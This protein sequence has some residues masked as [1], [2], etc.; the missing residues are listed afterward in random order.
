MKIKAKIAGL[1]L[2]GTSFM[3]VPIFTYLIINWDK[4]TQ[5]VPG[6]VIPES[7]K[8]SAGMLVGL[9]IAGLASVGKIKLSGGWLF[10]GIMFGLSWTLRCIPFSSSRSRTD[11]ISLRNTRS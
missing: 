10:L 6:Q 4:Y 3:V 2:L 7:V 8:L 9:T 5:T 11:H 1:Q